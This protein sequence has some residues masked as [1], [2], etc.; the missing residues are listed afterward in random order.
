MF[1]INILDKFKDVTVFRYL[2][3]GS[4]FLG[5]FLIVRKLVMNK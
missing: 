1:L 4:S 2:I 3:V 5:L